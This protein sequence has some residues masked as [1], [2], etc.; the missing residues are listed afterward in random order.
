MHGNGTSNANRSNLIYAYGTG[1]NGV[2]E[3]TG[4]LKVSQSITG[5]LFGSATLIPVTASIVTA[6]S[7][8]FDTGSNK[9]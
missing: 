3:I 1:N 5:S 9:L 7:I 6:G 2:V 4:S 8:Y